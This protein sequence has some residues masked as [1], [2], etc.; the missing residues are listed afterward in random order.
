VPGLGA[1]VAEVLNVNGICCLLLLL[2]LLLQRCHFDILRNGTKGRAPSNFPAAIRGSASQNA[3]NSI[4][5][6]DSNKHT[7]E[8][9]RIVL[10]GGCLICWPWL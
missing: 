6:D 8:L 3:H 4:I 10:P 2:I 5:G 1:A 7:E 9:R